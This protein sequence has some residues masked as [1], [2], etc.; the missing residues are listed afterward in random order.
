M[1]RELVYLPE[2]SRDFA[3]A[4]DCYASFSATAGQRFRAAF[5]RAEQEIEDGL[6]TRRLVFDFYH[7]VILKPFPYILYYRLEGSK[8]VIVG[9][10]YA[11]LHPQEI[12][13]AL[14]SRNP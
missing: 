9:L 6:I 12:E 2:V 7:R 11:R 4:Y 13:A 1:R 3:Q 8:A 5:D 14:K 10:L